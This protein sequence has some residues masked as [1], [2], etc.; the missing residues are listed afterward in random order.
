MSSFEDNIRVRL[1]QIE[2]MIRT[3]KTKDRRQLQRER[4]DL[5]TKLLK[6]SNS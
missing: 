5:E 6:A 4:A 1:A 2:L 3:A